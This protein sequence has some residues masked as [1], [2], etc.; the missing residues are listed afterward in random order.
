MTHRRPTKSSSCLQGSSLCQQ[1]KTEHP[2]TTV[3]EIGRF[4]HLS[5]EVHTVNSLAR[6]PANG[7]YNFS[8]V[9]ALDQKSKGLYNLFRAVATV[10]GS[11]GTISLRWN[12]PS[13]NHLSLRWIHQQRKRRRLITWKKEF[14]ASEACPGLVFCRMPN[15]LIGQK[16]PSAGMQ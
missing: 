7:E 16:C 6:L 9:L 14:A 5:H 2:G 3:D 15:L 11:S 12:N 8:N 13:S 4:P 10:L 1:A